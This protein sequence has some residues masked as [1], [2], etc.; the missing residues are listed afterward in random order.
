[1][2]RIF[3]PGFTTRGVGVGAGLGLSICWQIVERHGGGIEVDSD[4]GEGATFV[5]VLPIDGA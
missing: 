3:D 2:D 1:M 5:V 4:S